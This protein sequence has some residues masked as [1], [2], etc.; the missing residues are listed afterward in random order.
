MPNEKDAA[1]VP[2]TQVLEELQDLRL[3]RASKAVVGSSAIIR[4]GSSASAMAI[5]TR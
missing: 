3:R 4:A 5:I 1:F 2:R